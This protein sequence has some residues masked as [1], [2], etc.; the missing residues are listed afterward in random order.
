MGIAVAG[1]VSQRRGRATGVGVMALAHLTNDSYA[2]MLPALLPVLL[3]RLDITVG[4]AGIL[5]TLYQAS[6]SFT[7]PFF[8]HLADRGSATRWM[9]WTGVALSGLAAGALGLAPSFA[10]L[11]LALLAGGLGTALYH[12]VSAALVA[13]AVPGTSRGRWMS[14]YISAGNFGLPIGPLVLGLLLASIGLGGTWLVAL[15]ALAVAAL[16][17]RVGPRIAARREAAVSLRAVL[18]RERRML[19]GLVAV[20]ATRSWASSLVTSFLPLYAVARGAD[21]ITSSRLLTSFLLAGAIG[22]LAGGWLADRFGRDRVIVASLL[23]AAP[24]CALLATQTAVGPAFWMAATVSGLLLNGSFVV[25]AV[26]GQESMPGNLGMVSGLML[27]L[28]IGLGGLAVAPMAAVA[29]RAGL[30]VVLYAAGV[31]SVAGAAIMSRVPK[32][33]AAPRGGRAAPS[34]AAAERDLRVTSATL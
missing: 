24:F 7:Q 13:S 9:A 31:L 28:S 16:V 18:R 11:A 4:L 1:S 33:P 29:E 5:V 10:V 22:G 2:Y 27:G 26:R 19:A 20:S 30:P 12:P 21:V 32:P 23:A 6:S 17:W 25:L 8:G 3:T 15:P 14:V 34:L